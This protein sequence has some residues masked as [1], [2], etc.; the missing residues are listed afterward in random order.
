LI[1]NEEKNEK[2]I[3]VMPDGNWLSH[4]SRPSEIAKV[5]REMGYEVVFA[6]DGYYMKLPREKDFEVLPIITISP[7]RV[8]KCSRSGRDKEIIKSRE[9]KL[10]KARELRVKH[11]TNSTLTQHTVLSD[12]R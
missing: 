5:L 9:E 10:A 12:S 6:S 3:L 4:V 11:N 7:D 2:K 8:L 1:I